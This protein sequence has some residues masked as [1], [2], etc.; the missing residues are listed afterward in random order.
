MA[1]TIIVNLV[2]PVRREKLFIGLI[3]LPI[4]VF[5]IYLDRNHII[6][7]G[8]RLRPLKTI[9]ENI[10]RGLDEKR[11]TAESRLFIAEEVAEKLPAPCWNPGMAPFMEG[12]FQWFFPPREMNKFTLS[13]EEAVWII[14]QDDYLTI[15][16]V[17]GER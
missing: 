9:L 17:S 13:Q 15:K 2:R 6:T 10:S 12:T 7:V 11:I 14:T 5:N 4:L 3:L 1:V 16:P 8:N